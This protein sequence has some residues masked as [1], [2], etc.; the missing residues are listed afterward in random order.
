MMVYFDP[1]PKKNAVMKVW[2]INDFIYKKNLET[3]PI[4]A[5]IDLYTAKSDL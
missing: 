4:L 1:P 2:A 5:V 3:R